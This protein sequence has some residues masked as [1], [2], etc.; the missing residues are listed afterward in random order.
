MTTAQDLDRIIATWLEAEAA[1]APPMAGRAS[2]AEALTARRPLPAWRATLGS[3][4]IA[5]RTSRLVDAPTRRTMT[6]AFAVAAFRGPHRRR[7]PRRRSPAASR[8]L[9]LT[10]HRGDLVYSAAG[11]I[12]VAGPDGNASVRI[13]DGTDP[14]WAPDNHHLLF[15]QVDPAHA[16]LTAADHTTVIVADPNGHV[17]GSFP[18]WMSAWS[19]DSS[20]I[21]TWEDGETIGIWS[22]DGT[23]VGGL[24]GLPR[25]GDAPPRWSPDG[26]AIIISDGDWR[27]EPFRIA[28]IP[29]DGSARH[30][31]D[32]P[33]FGGQI[34]PDGV[35]V[36][37]TLRAV[38]SSG[39]LL[40]STVD[41]SEPR[42]RILPSDLGPDSFDP[43]GP[44][45]SP[46]SDRVAFVSFTPVGSQVEG[47]ATTS[48]GSAWVYDTASGAS[49][50][51]TRAE[52]LWWPVRWSPDGGEL[53]LERSASPSG[54]L[55]TR[56]RHGIVEY[57]QPKDLTE[58]S[59]WVVDADGTNLTRL[60]DAQ[61]GDWQW[62]PDR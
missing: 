37:S 8:T 16:V 27:Q 28:W 61:S 45:W 12:F 29:I 36:A 59:L 23:R 53:L 32:A 60:T 40:L 47:V 42:T 49:T 15:Q 17:V 20:L 34:A 57:H 55:W 1:P 4:W 51:L 38:S 25:L 41:D 5:G 48:S 58:T 44:V 46:A 2:L 13:G 18:G 21:A 62:V 43:S 56:D 52:G 50:R 39:A 7:S 22:V 31:I 24:V 35:H 33:G 30:V 10:F 54:A 3:H 11:G 14:V 9:A 6:V 19:P 26:L